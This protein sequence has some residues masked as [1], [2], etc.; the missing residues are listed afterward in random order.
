MNRPDSRKIVLPNF[1]KVDATLWRGG[2]PDEAGARW[3]VA[4]G[5]RTVVNLE[6][7]QEDDDVFGYAPAVRFVR[8]KDFEPLPWFAPS[9][10]DHHARR[11]LAVVRSG[12]TPVYVHCRSGENRTGVMVAA[13]QLIVKGL[14]L[15][16]VLDEFDRFRGFWAWGDFRYIRSLDARR[17]SFR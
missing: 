17:L 3:L 1:A 13:Y 12:S 16:D 8:V 11:F 9:V 6:W 14:L 10:S 5:V 4:E 2:R 7:E 15:D